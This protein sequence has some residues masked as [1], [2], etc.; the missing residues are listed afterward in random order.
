MN[1][2]SCYSLYLHIIVWPWERLAK[3]RLEHPAPPAATLTPSRINQHQKYF[4]N[5]QEGNW[6]V[7]IAPSA[8]TRIELRCVT[9]DTA[10]L[11]RQH[12][13]RCSRRYSMV[14]C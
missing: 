14:D 4:I 11:D 8:P 5:L 2:S 6:Y 10:D 13:K 9:V 1:V 7:K 12:T 3:G